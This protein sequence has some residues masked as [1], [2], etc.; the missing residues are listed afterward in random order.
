MRINITAKATKDTKLWD[1][2]YRNLSKPS[3]AVDVGWWINTHP[4]GVPVAQ[5]AAWNEE[6]H[7]TG[8]GGYSPP[9][10]FVRVDWMRIVKRSVVPKYA[11]KVNDVALGN[12]PWRA[13]NK[14]MAEELKEAMQK[15]IL[16]FSIPA[17]SPLTV[18][19]KGHG[20]V[21]IDSGTMYDRVKTRIRRHKE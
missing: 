2:I 7:M 21:L 10:P 19:I 6:G 13:L 12:L 9:R 17:N 15:A 14:Q 20:D 4:T 3:G 11:K 1:K 18:K 8:F 16:D 5:V